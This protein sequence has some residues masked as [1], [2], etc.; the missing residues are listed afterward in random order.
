MEQVDV[1]PLKGVMPNATKPIKVN[2][3]YF[4]ISLY[5]RYT[6]SSR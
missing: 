3:F 2:V 1:N 6:W 5:I 4:N